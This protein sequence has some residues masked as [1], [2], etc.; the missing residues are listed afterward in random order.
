MYDIIT[1]GG[2]MRDIFFYTN[3]G[4]I[5]NNPKD[6]LREKLICFELGAK[7]YIKEIIMGA[8]GGASNTATGLS[9]LGLKTAIVVRV[10]Q[11]R[12][13]DQLIKDMKKQGVETSLIQRDPKVSTGFSFITALDKKKSHV[14]FAF[15]GANDKLI[16]PKV[17]PKS[18]WLYIS[19]LSCPKWKQILDKLVKSPALKAWNPS[20][21]QLRSGYRGLSKYLKKTYVLILNEDEARELVLSAKHI[22]DL[23][24]K[25]LLKELFKMGPKIISITVGK[26]GAYAYDGK[27]IYFQSVIPVKVLNATG[28]GDSFSSGFVAS[29]C[30]KINDLQRALRWGVGNSSMV[31][32]EVGAQRGL[33]NLKQIKK[34]KFSS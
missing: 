22:K 17:L 24:I 33:L 10:G 30:Y 20:T 31:V 13:A 34:L 3:E 12:E 32:A 8:G 2:V 19:S 4:L 9:I 6:P 1:I 5:I 18:K 16:Y 7:I 26:K 14:L 29:L 11:D 21:V 23:S 27:K 15:R 25:N 28:A